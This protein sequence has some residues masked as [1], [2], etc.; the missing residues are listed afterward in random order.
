M[1]TNKLMDQ[2]GEPTNASRMVCC[3]WCG[4]KQGTGSLETAIRREDLW[5]L[6]AT[7]R[8]CK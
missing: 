6:A 8:R 5:S 4:C 3:N 2:T 1:Y 7:Q